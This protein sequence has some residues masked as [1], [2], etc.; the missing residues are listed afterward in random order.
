M[1]ADPTLQMEAKTESQVQWQPDANTS[2]LLS[3]F[4]LLVAVGAAAVS[5]TAVSEAVGSVTA[6]SVTAG[7]VPCTVGVYVAQRQLGST[8]PT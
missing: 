1:S 6:V 8:V 3:S 7:S 5:V 2:E 4:G